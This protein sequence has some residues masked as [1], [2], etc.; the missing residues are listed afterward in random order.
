MKI[1][2]MRYMKGSIV[3]LEIVLNFDKFQL[4]RKKMVELQLRIQKNRKVKNITIK[5]STKRCV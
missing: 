3:M 5:L 1:S 4:V 2:F